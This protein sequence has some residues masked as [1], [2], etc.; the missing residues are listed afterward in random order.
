MKLVSTRLMVLTGIALTS[1]SPLAAETTVT[2]G[3]ELKFD[4]YY[5]TSTNSSTGPRG[6]D[7]LSFR[8]IPLEET[9]ASEKAGGTKFHSRA[10]KLYVQSATP[11]EG[12][13]IK[14]HLEGDFLGRVDTGAGTDDDTVSNSYEFRLRQA[15]ISWGN[16]MV[17]QAWSNFVDLKAYPEGLTFTGTLGRAFS[18]QAQIR[19]TTQLG[20]GDTFSFSLENPDTDYNAGT[21][22]PGSNANEDDS[23]PDMIGTYINKMGKGHFRASL[24]VRS[25]GVDTTNT[26]TDLTTAQSDTAMGW[27]IGLSGKVVFTGQF[28]LKWNI[29]GGDG[30]G[31]YLYNNQFRSA[32]FIDGELNTEQAWGGNVMLQ[33][34]PSKDLRMNFGY[35]GH[36][37]DVESDDIVG[38]VTEKLASTHVN[39]IWT[40]AEKLEVGAG[41][42]HATRDVKNGT[43]GDITRLMFS[44]KR[45]FGATF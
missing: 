31:R 33:Y 1:A 10:T 42:T 14:T 17:G 6:Y 19:Y 12:G 23:I 38:S 28:N 41:L 40:I 35:G 3:G 16:W 7:L 13:T 25:L 36:S 22:V 5:D 24:L 11:F 9:G 4:G 2:V 43:Q 37:V 30:I 34:K 29:H 20:D 15:Y 32:T 27:G 18:R 26:V 21:P 44:V 45:K 39:A 8:S